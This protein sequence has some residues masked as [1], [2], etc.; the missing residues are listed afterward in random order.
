LASG[1]RSMRWKLV[2][3]ASFLSMKSEH[4]M[5]SIRLVAYLKAL[6]KPT[7]IEF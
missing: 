6:N 5:N 2:D 4:N 1:S 7:A 3:D